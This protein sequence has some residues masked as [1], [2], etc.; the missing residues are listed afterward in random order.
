MNAICGL[1]LS[2]SHIRLSSVIVVFDFSASLN[3]VNPLSLMLL[4]VDFMRMEECVVDR[5]P[6]CCFFCAHHSD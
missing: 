6:L 1:F 4:P 3:D 5:Y 2:S